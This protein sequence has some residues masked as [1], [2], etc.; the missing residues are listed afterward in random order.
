MRDA[1][2]PANEKSSRS[3]HQFAENLQTLLQDWI[4]R[5]HAVCWQ[6]IDNH[7]RDIRAPG[8][9]GELPRGRVSLQRAVE[10]LLFG[11]LEPDSLMGHPHG[12]TDRAH[13]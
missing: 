9:S 10:D 3:N 7:G 5:I 4:L 12:C 8:R 6:R 2:V 11:A 1:M 13:G